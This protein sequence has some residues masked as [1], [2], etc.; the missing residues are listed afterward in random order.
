MNFPKFSSMRRPYQRCAVKLADSARG[1]ST[2]SMK[3][4]RLIAN[5]S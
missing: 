1:P 5:H 4:I 3:S 2:G